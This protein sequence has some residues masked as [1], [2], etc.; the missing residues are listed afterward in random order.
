[1]VPHLKNNRTEG[2]AQPKQLVLEEFLTL[3]DLVSHYLALPHLQGLP[4]SELREEL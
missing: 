3:V 2:L 4:L 1:M